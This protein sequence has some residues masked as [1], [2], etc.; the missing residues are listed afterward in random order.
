MRIGICYN[1]VTSDRTDRSDPGGLM[2]Y[3]GHKVGRHMS[4][5]NV[6]TDKSPLVIGTVFRY[7]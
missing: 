1:M 6:K 7:V 2:E 4:I 5:Y 3:A